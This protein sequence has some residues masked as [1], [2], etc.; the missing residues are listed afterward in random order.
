[1]KSAI[2]LA[3]DWQGSVHSTHV[4]AVAYCRECGGGRGG[5]D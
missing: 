2:G 1:M 3:S 5:D 4:G